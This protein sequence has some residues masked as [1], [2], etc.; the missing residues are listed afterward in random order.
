MEEDGHG[1]QGTPQ[2]IIAYLRSRSGEKWSRRR[3][4]APGCWHDGFAAIISDEYDDYES[5][6]RWRPAYLANDEHYWKQSD[7][8][9]RERD[10]AWPAEGERS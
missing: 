3:H 10:E 9:W 5:A 7:A 6:A 8:F 1:H 2:E 4:S